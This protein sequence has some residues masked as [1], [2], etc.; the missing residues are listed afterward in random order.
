MERAE[1]GARKGIRSTFLSSGQGVRQ[2]K[3]MTKRWH[4]TSIEEGSLTIRWHSLKV[5]RME[6]E[7]MYGRERMKR[8]SRRMRRGGGEE[9]G[10]ERGREEVVG[11]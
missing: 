5:W 11:G 1:L 6:E 7:E 3:R 10:G 8:I 4:E 2:R 9:E